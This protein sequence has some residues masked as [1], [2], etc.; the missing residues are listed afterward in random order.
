MTSFGCMVGPQY[1]GHKVHAENQIGNLI[2][3]R[4]SPNPPLKQLISEILF[5][6]L[7]NRCQEEA[8][9]VASVN[10]CVLSL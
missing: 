3:G 4:H 7:Y 2:A 8:Q 6:L 1:M 5:C 9:L 10:L